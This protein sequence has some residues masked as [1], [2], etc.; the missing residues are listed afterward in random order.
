MNTDSSLTREMQSP[1]PSRASDGGSSRAGLG[2]SNAERQEHAITRIATVEAHR[3]CRPSSPVLN[4]PGRHAESLASLSRAPVLTLRDNG[5][6]EGGGVTVAANRA[7]R[8]PDQVTPRR[9]VSVREK[10]LEEID[11]SHHGSIRAHARYFAADTRRVS[12][13]AEKTCS[14]RR[15]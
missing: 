6:E 5:L 15:I 11:A 10:P 12:V 13:R 1:L 9:L 2:R 7:D 3:A 4:R 14:K 8:Q